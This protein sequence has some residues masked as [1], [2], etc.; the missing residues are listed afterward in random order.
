VW[1]CEKSVFVVG[2]GGLISYSVWGS[3]AANVY[4]ATEAGIAHG[5]SRQ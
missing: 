2:D 4:L 5:V 3:S 1:S